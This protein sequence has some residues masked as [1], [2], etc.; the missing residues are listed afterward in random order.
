MAAY[1]IMDVDIHDIGQYMAYMKQIRPLLEAAGAHYRV[2]GG[3]F[4]VMEGDWQ[5]QRLVIVEFPTMDEL[6][7]FYASEPY[8]ALK[9]T[10]DACSRSNVVAVEGLELGS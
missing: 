2:R 1:A 4:T 7:R 8:L 6:E 9:P 3:P 10:R 5:P